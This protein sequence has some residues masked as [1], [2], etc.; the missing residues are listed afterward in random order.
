MMPISITSSVQ[1]VAFSIAL[2]MVYVSRR[3]VAH[4]D[5]STLIAL[6]ALAGISR[7]ILFC[8]FLAGCA[9]GYMAG[10]RAEEQVTD[11]HML[12]RAP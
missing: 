7:I 11:Q 1:L 5:R 12:E 2:S 10:H 4:Q 3:T 9:M 8:V 6:V